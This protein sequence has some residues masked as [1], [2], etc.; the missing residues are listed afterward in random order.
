MVENV[1]VITAPGQGIDVT[2]MVVTGNFDPARLLAL[3]QRLLPN[4]INDWLNQLPGL[5]STVPGL[6][7]P[8]GLQIPGWNK[9]LNDAS[10]VLSSHIEKRISDPQTGTNT[11]HP[12][13]DSVAGAGTSAV[14]L[15]ENTLVFVGAAVAMGLAVVAIGQ[16]QRA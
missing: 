10:S 16:A 5:L 13:V 6:G 2:A 12:L 3:L 15:A 7:T 11:G 4:A 8:G 9:F 14:T 1:V